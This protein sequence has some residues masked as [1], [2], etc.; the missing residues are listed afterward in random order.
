M[1]VEGLG[2]AS[3]GPP[4]GNDL[5]D[6]VDQEVARPGA[7]RRTGG[8][9][10]GP[11]WLGDEADRNRSPLAGPS[12]A[13]PQPGEARVVSQRRVESWSTIGATG[14]AR[15]GCRPVV[16]PGVRRGSG[17][18][19]GIAVRQRLRCQDLPSVATDGA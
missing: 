1:V 19:V 4:S 8:D 18:V 15:T 5:D 3:E 10:N 2:Q 16:T 7:V 14:R 6:G 11:I 12:T 9:E 17:P 13:G